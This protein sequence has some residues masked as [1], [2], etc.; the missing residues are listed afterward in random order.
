[1]W[2]RERSSWS[3]D[4]AEYTV[5]R[6]RRPFE[7]GASR[8]KLCLWWNIILI[9]LTSW[10]FSH[11]I[12]NEIL[13][14]HLLEIVI[15][16]SYRRQITLEKHTNSWRIRCFNSPFGLLCLNKLVPKHFTLLQLWVS[17]LYL[18][19]LKNPIPPNYFWRCQGVLTYFRGSEL[20]RLSILTTV[21]THRALMLP[22]RCLL[23]LDVCLHPCCAHSDH[24]LKSCRPSADEF[25]IPASCLSWKPRAPLIKVS[26]E[27]LGLYSARSPTANLLNLRC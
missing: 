7:G 13:E 14:G 2:G 18:S 22:S 12:K 21:G 5:G 4:V 17:L 20:V 8:N 19:H 10:C 11:L 25:G 3:G 24:L 23:G 15:T 9:C 16:S 27:H 6:L 26:R 1:M